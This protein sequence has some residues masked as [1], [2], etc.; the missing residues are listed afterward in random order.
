MRAALLLVAGVV[1]LA[2]AAFAPARVGA[3][4]QPVVSPQVREVAK[5]VRYKG[6]RWLEVES[7]TVA[8]STESSVEVRC[9]CLRF[10][11]T[12]TTTSPAPGVN[13]LSRLNF[14][15]QPRNRIQLAVHKDGLIGRYVVLRAAT[16]LSKE[17]LVEVASGCL[18]GTARVPCPT[19][20]SP[21]PEKTES[22]PLSPGPYKETAGGLTHTHAEYKS[23]GGA[24][25][26]VIDAGQTV[27]VRCRVEGLAVEDGDV[28]WYRIASVPWSDQYYASADAFYNNGQT[29]GSL[30]GTPPYDPAVGEC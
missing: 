18:E 16:P 19:P 12:S 6:A 24:E 4:E 29:S 5:T 9:G 10:S 11:N 28:W 20:I 21:P 26:S 1:A 23:G 8:S 30:I 15:L 3:A 2:V 7:L 13:R 17:K 27:E 22:Q 25:G 14:L